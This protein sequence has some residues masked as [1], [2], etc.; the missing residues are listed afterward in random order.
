[1]QLRQACE[2]ALRHKEI[3]ETRAQVQAVEGTVHEL[4]D[5]VQ[6][7]E[8]CLSVGRTGMEF[9]HLKSALAYCRDMPPNEDELDKITREFE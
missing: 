2:R 4:A 9:E 5:R 1:M 6:A 3:V 7:A 8:Q